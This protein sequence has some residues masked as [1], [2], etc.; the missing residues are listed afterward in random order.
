MKKYKCFIN[1]EKEEQWLNEMA[2]QGYQLVK[3]SSSSLYRFQSAN[4]DNTTI[5]IDYRT[6]KKQEDFVDYCTLFEDSGWEHIAGTK[7]SG[8]QYFRKINENGSEDIF[9][10]ADSKAGRYQ[11]LSQMWLALATCFIPIFVAL[12][13]TNTIDGKAL[14]NPKLLY[15]TPGLWDKVGVHFW[16]SF[17][18]ETPFVIIRGYLWAFFPVLIVLYLIF[19]LKANKQYRKTQVNK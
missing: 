1:F 3:K 7:N 6:F 19:A 16:R 11:R 9:S 17:L 4:P 14:L 2:K 8:A 5:K 10:D 15:Y 18:F 13:S 12:V